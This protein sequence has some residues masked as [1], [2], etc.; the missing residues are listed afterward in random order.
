[1]ADGF[2][3]AGY[4]D[5]L[6]GEWVSTP[7]STLNTTGPDIPQPAPRVINTPNSSTGQPAFADPSATGWSTE[8]ATPQGGQLTTLTPSSRTGAPAPGIRNLPA[9]GS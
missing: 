5:P 1:M 9:A 8:F 7:G 6:T 3:G 2:G 4:I